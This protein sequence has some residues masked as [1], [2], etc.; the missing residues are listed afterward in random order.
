MN[1]PITG[2]K[3]IVVAV[4][5]SEPSELALD[6]GLAHVAMYPETELHVIHAIP[7]VGRRKTTR[8]V[9]QEVLLS[10]VPQALHALVARRG[11]ALEVFPVH[12]GVHVRTGDPVK[13]ILQL[14]VDVEAEVL[15]IG[16][17]GRRGI[18][19]AVMGS[20]AERVVRA[21]RCPVW[22]ARAVDYRGL[23]PSETIEPACP[24]C[25]A[26][27]RASGGS[28]FWC[29]MHGRERQPAHTY[30]WTGRGWTRGG[31]D[32]HGFGSA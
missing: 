15:I 20:V 26:V 18:R 29:E 12:L 1:A 22:V 6:A 31:S 9:N 30:S 28:I 7:D 11:S 3:R 25:V 13:A 21:A 27:R 19:R 14:T 2:A 23:E 24:D 16:T 4:D 32:A 5:F 8:I 17:H 10:E